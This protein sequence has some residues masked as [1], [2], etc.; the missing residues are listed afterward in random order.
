MALSRD[1]KV[2]LAVAAI[3]GVTAVGLLIYSR[4]A[5]AAL[6]S[7]GAPRTP[8]LPTVTPQRARTPVAEPPPAH[9]FT[10]AE[11]RRFKRILVGLQYQ[12]VVEDFVVN[13]LIDLPFQQALRMFQ[14]AY[15]AER[16]A[17]YPDWQPAS[18]TVDG[19]LGPRTAQALEH[20]VDFLAP[21]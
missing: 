17:S 3:L 4:S 2:V 7:G 10:P 8:A 6:P 21:E 18:L 16:A 13:G 5:R 11:I 1:E 9:E 20:Y 19:V 12:Q 14:G 15:N